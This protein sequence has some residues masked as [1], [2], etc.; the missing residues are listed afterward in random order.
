M[1]EE[2]AG[3]A[4]GGG[5]DDVKV[6]VVDLSAE[7][8]ELERNAGASPNFEHLQTIAKTGR[9]PYEWKQLKLVIQRAFGVVLKQYKSPPPDTIAGEPLN[10]WINRIEK[11]I[12]AFTRPPWTLQRIC[13]VMTNPKKTCRHAELFV[14][15]MSKLICGIR[16]RGFK[17]DQFGLSV[18]DDGASDSR[19]NAY[20]LPFYNAPR[21]RT[22]EEPAVVP[23]SSDVS[24]IGHIADAVMSGV[25]TMHPSALGGSKGKGKPEQ[26]LE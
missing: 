2:A 22:T 24:K 11:G 21:L 10:V 19:K 6:D 5:A 8:A 26:A 14:L 7:L 18:P 20:Q 13:E 12:V 3:A 1:S 17:G 25:A 4:A 23:I 16:E 15:T 9:S